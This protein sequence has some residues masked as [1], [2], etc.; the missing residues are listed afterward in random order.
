[1][2]QL[3]DKNPLEAKLDPLK[4]IIIV[5]LGLFLLFFPKIGFA[6]DFF[7]EDFDDYSLGEFYGNGVWD[8]SATNSF[9][10]TSDVWKSFPQSLEIN[11]ASPLKFI[12]KDKGSNVSE[13]VFKFSVKAE[14]LASSTSN[15]FLFY[16]YD[17]NGKYVFYG[18]C[19]SNNS[20]NFIDCCYN[21]FV[22]EP[23]G[24][25]TIASSTIPSSWL[26]IYIQWNT[27]ASPSQMRVKSGS[28]NWSDWEIT[29]NDDSAGVRVI[30]F[31]SWHPSISGISYID[32]FIQSEEYGVCGSGQDC[33]Y[34]YNQ[35]DCENNGCYW[36][37]LPFY[38]LSVCNPFDP[39]IETATGTQ[40]NF[41]D[42][43][44]TNSEFSTPTAFISRLAS[45]T[46]PYLLVLSSWIG[47]FAELFDLSEAQLRG[48]Q[49][50][51]SIPRARGY[52]NF[53]DG[54][55]SDLPLSEILLFYLVVLIGII[56]FRVIRQIKKLIAV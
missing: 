19:E 31:E 50:G 33:I 48:E 3:F 39:Y 54:I 55:F 7:D 28:T 51:N 43:Y 25:N 46:Q 21:N 5:G 23:C 18:Q 24:D 40:F 47:N 11:I 27:N 22:G 1:M 49:L 45:A 38:G 20:G 32:S 44:A 42:Y 2:D 34:C 35:N 14:E 30:K 26:D 10:I 6:T 56:I 41:T 37:E 8:V 15:Y 13:G 12:L 16:G 29:R 9:F 52:L 17:N 36:I 4:I 53:F